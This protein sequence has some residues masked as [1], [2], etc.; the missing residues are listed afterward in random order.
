MKDNLMDF[1]K[2]VQQ[3]FNPVNL[4]LIFLE[5]V[6]LIFVVVTFVNVLFLVL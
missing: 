2:K 3:G 5:V 6:F 1:Q 4:V